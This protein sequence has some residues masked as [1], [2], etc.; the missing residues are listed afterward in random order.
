MLFWSLT[1]KNKFSL[2]IIS[3][4]PLWFACESSHICSLH[5]LSSLRTTTTPLSLTRG[6]NLPWGSFS[7]LSL[8][9]TMTHGVEFPR[10]QSAEYLWYHRDPKIAS[11]CL[12]YLIDMKRD[13][14]YFPGFAQTEEGLISL[15]QLPSFLLHTSLAHSLICWIALGRFLCILSQRLCQMWAFPLVP[16]IIFPEIYSAKLWLVWAQFAFYSKHISF[17]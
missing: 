3:H 11:K 14:K 7:S 4:K 12:H 9:Y 5:L 16:L 15:L 1:E 2:H 13:L 6:S 10:R 8:I 17:I